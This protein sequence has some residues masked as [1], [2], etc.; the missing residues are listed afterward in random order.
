MRRALLT[1]RKEAPEVVVIA[2][3]P[4]TSLFYA[5]ERGAS[6]EQ[7]RGVVQEYAAIAYYWWRGRI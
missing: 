3:P 1:W 5:H 7:I 6:A 4:E 2:T